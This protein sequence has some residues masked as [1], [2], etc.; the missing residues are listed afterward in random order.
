VS[1]LALTA[2]MAA[3]VLVASMVS[4]ELGISVALAEILLGVVIGNATTTAIPS[5]FAFIGSFAPIVLAFLAGSEIDAGQLRRE[6]R[7]SGLLGFLSFAFPFGVVYATTHH[8]LGWGI[9]QGL[10]AGTALATTSVAIV[11]TVLLESGLAQTETGKRLMA[12][13]FVTDF[14]TA[15]TL[16]LLFTKP[17]WWLAPFSVAGVV[18]VAAVPRLFP[19]FFR[20]YGETVVEPEIKL[21]FAALFLLMWLGEHARSHAV[22]P[23][24]LLGLVLSAHYARNRAEHDR[25]RIVSF[26]FLT[27]FFFMKSGMRVSIDVL[28]ADLGVLGILFGAKMA[29]KLSLYPLVAR[30][31]RPHAAFATLLQSTGLTFGTIA[32]LY[33]LSAGIIGERKFSLLVATIVLSALIPTVV[34]QTVF[35]PRLRRAG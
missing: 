4:I 18:L 17:N 31:C 14:L 3:A 1:A 11:Y 6:W 27:P 24:F 12:S 26:A 16:S 5:W 30:S 21:V 10:I 32:S 15:L 34:A 29:A 28:W 20:R 23:A 19:W 33:G 22:L 7:V 25:L 13:T 8:L 9:Q 35:R 2:A